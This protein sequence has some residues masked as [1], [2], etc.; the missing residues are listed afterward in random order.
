MM[1]LASGKRVTHHR[2]VSKMLSKKR[3]TRIVIAAHFQSSIAFRY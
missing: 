3:S 2:R 1:V